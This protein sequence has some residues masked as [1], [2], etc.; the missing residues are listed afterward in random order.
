MG[1]LADQFSQVFTNNGAVALENGY[2]V[3][4]TGDG[5]A[6]AAIASTAL[7]VL[8][9]V[10]TQGAIP[11]NA[12]GTAITAGLARVRLVNGL[13]PVGGQRLWLSASP[14]LGTTVQPGD[15]P[16]PVG[17]VVDASRYATDQT[18]MAVIMTGVGASGGSASVADWSLSQ[19]RYFFI[20]N[21]NG[22]D[23]SV[24]Y[25]D[26]APG[27]AFTARA[28]EVAAAALKTLEEL[29]NRLPRVGASRKAVV[30]CKVRSDAGNYLNKAGA[31][32][33]LDVGYGGYAYLRFTGSTDLSNSTLDIFRAGAVNAT[34]ALGPNAD[35]S[36]TID[37]VGTFSIT[38]AAGALPAED[39]IAG[40]RVL[41]TGNVTPALTAEDGLVVERSSATQLELGRFHNPAPA[42]GDTYHL[43]TPGIRVTTIRHTPY[44]NGAETFGI[45]IPIYVVGF[46]FTEATFERLNGAALRFCRFDTTA[47][48]WSIDT[49]EAAGLLTETGALLTWETVLDCRGDTTFLYAGIAQ[50][51]AAHSAYHG[52]L[53]IEAVFGANPA[54]STERLILNAVYCVEA[55]TLI[56]AQTTGLTVG[57]TSG[58][59]NR[60]KLRA[61]IEVRGNVTIG[62]ADI[63]GATIGILVTG[64]GNFVLITASFIGTATGS[65]VDLSNAR[66]S[67]ALLDAGV[68]ATG[69]TQD[70]LLA[71]DVAT[72]FGGLANTNAVD[73]A[74]NNLQGTA[75][76][77]VDTCKRVNNRSGGALAVGDVVRGNG[78]D[79]QVTDAQADTA[80]NAE[81]LGVMVTP[82]ADEADGYMAPAG[83]PFA[84]FDGAPTPGAIAYLSPGTAKA[85][86]TTVPAMAATNQKLRVGRV[87]DVSGSTGRV[88]WH[89]E[90][91]AVTADGNA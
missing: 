61:G 40:Y 75:G 13:T 20:D 29:R 5:T 69:T 50:I 14:G 57:G 54:F 27:T 25:I 7:S 85:L 83:T 19:C 22:N 72:S 41:Y 30:L 12:R 17:Y 68:T 23:L 33:Y 71:G 91:L 1:S 28:G 39:T 88:S 59:S 73:E 79:N 38:N 60:A 42:A 51:A 3:A 52:S 21:E 36:W 48:I 35:F 49:D 90:N 44:P 65:A 66:Q 46:R 11:Q 10:Q 2:L 47:Q 70:T 9:A 43:T 32:D 26:D 76:R 80:G 62:R 8:G 67:T 45:F 81:V 74:G 84:T 82:P 56:C 63:T 58:I 77:V 24:G 4:P 87:V 34:D 18:V 15:F 55:P 31:P 53:R 64:E 6:A 37:S 16:V 86:T 78:T 89:P